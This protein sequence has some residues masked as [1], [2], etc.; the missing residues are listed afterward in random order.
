M[1]RE[2]NWRNKIPTC[3]VGAVDDATTLDEAR[4]LAR[5]ELDLVEEGEEAADDYTPR[6]VAAI[7]R[8]AAEV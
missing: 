4:W 2:M 7:R 3:L 6:D 1:R 5:I 8:F